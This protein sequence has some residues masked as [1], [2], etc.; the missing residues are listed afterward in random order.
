MV[1]ALLSEFAE[2]RTEIGNRTTAQNTLVSITLVAAGVISS[3]AFTKAANSQLVL[4]LGPLCTATGLLWLDNA[5]AIFQIGDY[6]KGRLWPQLRTALDDPALP[7]YENYIF[8]EKQSDEG[9]QGRHRRPLLVLERGVL[10]F[11]FA[12]VFILPGP[13]A[14]VAV[15]AARGGG[16]VWMPAACNGVLFAF[17]ATVWVRFLVKA[18]PGRPN[19]K[20]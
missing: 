12:V 19:N 13:I 2:L 10:I 5:H 8:E 1:T 14:T 15:L 6:I 18:L 20:A 9:G 16:W 4:F 11:P 17:L 3:I 7:S